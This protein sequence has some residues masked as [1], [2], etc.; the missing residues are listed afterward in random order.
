MRTHLANAAYDVL[1]D[2]SYPT[3]SVLGG[4][5]IAYALYGVT[6]SSTYLPLASWQRP[7]ITGRH[8]ISCTAIP[9]E[10]QEGSQS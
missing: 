3:V 1:H 6:M 2:G 4:L 5:P 8:R 7:E 10:V 9:S